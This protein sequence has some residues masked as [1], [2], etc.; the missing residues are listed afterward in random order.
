MAE[1]T[2]SLTTTYVLP[3]GDP[4]LKVDANVTIDTSSSTSDD[5]DGYSGATWS[6]LNYGALTANAANIGTW[7]IYLAGSSN[8]SVDNY[9]QIS[10][11]GGVDLAL[12]GSVTNEA[13]ATIAAKVAY[14]NG[15]Y[16]STIA[17]VHIAGGAGQGLKLR[18][19]HVRWR[20]WRGPRQRRTGLQLF[21]RLDHRRRRRRLFLRQHRLS[22]QCRPGHGDGRRRRRLLCRRHAAQRGYGRHQRPEYRLAVTA[23][24]RSTSPRSPGR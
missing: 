19:D 5:I 16:S 10:A 15:S 17:G 23:P 7:A 13:G 2:T 11:A 6:V 3:S 14:Q 18:R 8:N 21:R 20:L 12:G 1:L 9:G 24:P 22:G 4:N